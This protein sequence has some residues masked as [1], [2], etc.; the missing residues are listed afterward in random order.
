MD[1]S[2]IVAGLRGLTRLPGRALLVPLLTLLACRAP[3]AP[4]PGDSAAPPVDTAAADGGA[5]TGEDTAFAGSKALCEVRALDDLRADGHPESGQRSRVEATGRLQYE[6]YTDGDGVPKTRLEYRY[7]AS[8]NRVEE[9]HG[10]EADGAVDVTHTW[11]DDAWDA[12]HAWSYT[13]D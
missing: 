9:A 6:A 4:A 3:P 12:D 5:D 1:T 2:R 11:T 8:G 7:A 13:R 10:L